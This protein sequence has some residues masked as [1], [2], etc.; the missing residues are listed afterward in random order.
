M[1]SQEQQN[2]IQMNQGETDVEF[3]DR[4]TVKPDLAIK[5]E[6][7]YDLYRFVNYSYQGVF[8]TVRKYSI[9]AYCQK[10]KKFVMTNVTTKKDKCAIAGY[11]L[12]GLFSL[13]IGWLSFC[14]EDN[15][16]IFTHN[17]SDCN[18]YIVDSRRR[19]TAI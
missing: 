13:T 15:Y 19:M 16:K 11:L 18:Q 12:F 14:C 8:C 3:T 9:C 5:T 6:T 10:C 7:G 17:C 2:I 1:Q 4:F